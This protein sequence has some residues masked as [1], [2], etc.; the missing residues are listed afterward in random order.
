MGWDGRCR[1]VTTRGGA[2]EGRCGQ[3]GRGQARRQAWPGRAEPGQSGPAPGRTWPGWSGPSGA[4]AA[5]K[6]SRYLMTDKNIG[7]V[8]LIYVTGFLFIF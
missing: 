2:K 1:D 5:M 7:G 3:D 4:T 6:M 8:Q